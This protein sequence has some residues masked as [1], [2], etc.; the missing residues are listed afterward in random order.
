MLRILGTCLWTVV[1]AV[2]ASAAAHAQDWQA[3]T[4]EAAL[5]EVVSDTQLEGTL[6]D[7]VN[8]V[9]R[10]NADGTAVLE[11]WG[12]TFERRW[13]IEDDDKICVDAGDETWCTSIEQNVSNPDEYRATRLDTGEQVVFSLSEQ[14]GS[15]VTT[16]QAGN[17]GGPGQP[18]AEELALSLIHI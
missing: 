15:L 17:A 1:W 18:S 13:R 4:G 2:L 11:A 14:A 8:A 3:V 16:S 5:K 9:A 10:Y 6:K 7:D 12:G